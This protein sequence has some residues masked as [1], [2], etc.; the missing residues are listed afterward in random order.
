[1]YYLYQLL[2][3][4]DKTLSKLQ[5]NATT[6]YNC[7]CFICDFF[8]SKTFQ[9]KHH[10]TINCKR[11][12]SISHLLPTL[13][14]HFIFCCFNFT[15]SIS[16]FTS[17]F[18]FKSILQLYIYPIYSLMT[19]KKNLIYIYVFL[20][21]YLSLIEHPYMFIQ[22]KISLCKRQYFKYLCPFINNY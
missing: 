17:L 9:L 18:H 16:W 10:M 13:F 19:S 21:F 3:F 14:R 8:P 4:Y 2:T 20:K 15:I 11:L 1:M 6:S 7:V 12:G 5:L 22:H